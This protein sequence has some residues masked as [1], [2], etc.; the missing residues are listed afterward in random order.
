MFQTVSGRGS[1]QNQFV[2]I[3]MANVLAV[4][5]RKTIPCSGLTIPDRWEE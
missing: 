5:Q 3:L 1:G 2:T 4:F